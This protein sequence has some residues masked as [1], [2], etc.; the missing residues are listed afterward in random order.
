VT[1]LYTYAVVDSASVA[2]LARDGLRLIPGGRIAA[3]VEDVEVEEF[4]GDRL[5][6]NLADR[7]WLERMVRHH[8]SIIEGLL[9]GRAVVP[10][11]FGSI[12]ST[13]DGLRRMLEESSA[14]FA[15]MLDRVRGRHEWGVRVNAD[16]DAM[17]RQ[18][19]PV[20]RDASTGGDYLRR[21]RAE[22]Q[23]DGEVG[24]E[25]ARIAR[26]LHEQLTRHAELAVVLQPRQPAPETLVTTA[27]LVP[28]DDQ[29]VFL[30]CVKE[31]DNEYD[32]IS[33]DV[34][35]PWP[36]YSFISADVGGPRD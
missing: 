23:A 30:A 16:R 4:E 12:F 5:E 3:V 7:E 25:A 35:G 34:T 32:G 1:G 6:R 13:E 27:Y 31:L 2:D 22:M 8:E 15:A 17:V 33:L 26:E 24:I 29:D 18:L 21:R 20:A 11:R 9:D 36:P 10:M 19:A 14:D 28:F